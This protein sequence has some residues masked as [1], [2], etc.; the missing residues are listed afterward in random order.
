[1]ATGT[2]DVATGMSSES[3]HVAD[4]AE[5]DNGRVVSSTPETRIGEKS[6]RLVTVGVL[7][8][9]SSSL[10]LSPLSLSSLSFEFLSPQDGTFRVEVLSLVL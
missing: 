1:M 9:V 4:L 10:T 8:N 2:D 5:T 7:R 6:S 3:R